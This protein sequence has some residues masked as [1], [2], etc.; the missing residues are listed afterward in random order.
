VPKNRL[1]EADWKQF[2]RDDAAPDPALALGGVLTA[3]SRQLRV[4]H[5]GSLH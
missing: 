4:A 1:A 2:L 3:W 5:T